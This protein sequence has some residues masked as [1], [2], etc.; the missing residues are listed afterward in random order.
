MCFVCSEP[1]LEELHSIYGTHYFEGKDREVGYTDYPSL[2][3][4]LNSIANM[5]LDIIEE[6]SEKGNLLDVGC[7]TGEFLEAAKKRGWSAHG[8]EISEYGSNICKQKGL[9]VN[10]GILDQAAL[11]ENHFDVVTM[12]DVLEHTPD[13]YKEL[14]IVN[15]L[16]KKKGLICLSVPNF[17]SLRAMIERKNWWAFFSSREHLYF[18]TPK[19]IT[20]LLKKTGFTVIYLRTVCIDISRSFLLNYFIR[21]FSDKSFQDA[22]I[23]SYFPSKNILKK[24][25]EKFRLGHVLLVIGRK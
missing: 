21:N 17:G 12:W 20:A 5:H 23:I 9:N 11:P 18:F 6:M 19:T 2:S 13:P 15:R 10:R 1:S 24:L 16:V 25:L 7:A 22:P 14:L 3:P 4:L 8:I